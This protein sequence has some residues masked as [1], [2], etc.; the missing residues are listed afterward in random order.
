MTATARHVVPVVVMLAVALQLLD[1]LTYSLAVSRFPGGEANPL[2]TAPLETVIVKTAGIVLML[3]IL[4]RVTG[5]R[6]TVGA[7]I[8]GAVGAF[9]A[10][11]N[12]V[13]G[14]FA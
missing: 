10:V 5:K 12:V 14:V 8:A 7:G 2:M 4:A 3:V 1:M 6:R 13:F 11:T 9:G